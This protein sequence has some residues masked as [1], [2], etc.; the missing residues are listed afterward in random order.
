MNRLPGSRSLREGRRPRWVAPGAFAFA[1][2]VAAGCARRPVPPSPSL[3]AEE[4]CPALAGRPEP[5]AS[6]IFALGEPVD[7]AN[8]PLPD[9]AAEAIVFA[10]LYET[11][12]AVDCRGR[13]FPGLAEAWKASEDK[14][15]WT[16]TLRRDAHFWDGKRVRAADVKSAWASERRRLRLRGRLD[17]VWE[18]IRPRF[19]RVLDDRRLVVVLPRARKELPH[20]LSNPAFA[21]TRRIP[22]EPWPLGTATLRVDQVG[23]SGEELR[24]VPVTSGW[25]LVRSPASIIFRILRDKDP[26]DLLAE[27]ADAVLARDRAACE[28]LARRSDLY[29]ATALPWD[30]LYLLL[31]PDDTSAAPAIRAARANLARDVVGSDAV[32]WESALLDCL[33]L[34]CPQPLAER[35]PFLEKSHRGRLLYPDDDREARSLAARIAYL[36]ATA[37]SGPAPAIAGLSRNAFREAVARGDGAAIILPLA[38]RFAVDCLQVRELLKAAPWLLEREAAEAAGLAE[39]AAVVLDEPMRTGRV[40]PLVATRA[41]LVTRTGLS[42]V[43]FDFDGVPRLARAGWSVEGSLP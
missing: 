4:D 28:Y 32:P 39:R 8:S 1:V 42:G 43:R 12:I 25:G 3:L 11:L 21:V 27:G 22:G 15:E 13:I 16:F 23:S 14:R 40:T 7:A 38:R 30:R 2:I 18:E 9:N 36:L 10:N 5:G 6:L 31:F 17:W 20:L 29:T 41:H 24:I 26:R 35:R 19:V 33:E 37:G 34:P